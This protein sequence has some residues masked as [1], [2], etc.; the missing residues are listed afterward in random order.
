[1][2]ERSHHKPAPKMKVTDY[3]GIAALVTA[4][5]VAL[6]TLW[7]R[8]TKVDEYERM[9]KG[10]LAVGAEQVTILKFRVQRLE[11]D[12]RDLKHEMHDDHR[13]RSAMSSQ[14]SGRFTSGPGAGRI[15]GHGSRDIWTG[16]PLQ[17][18][19]SPPP[20]LSEPRPRS[21]SDIYQML[22]KGAKDGKDYQ[23]RGYSH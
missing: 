3:A 6:G 17:V 12:F 20:R 14:P 4:F 7:D 5:S 21:P 13:A 23:P 11:N 8:N 2:A 19:E 15:G 9:H 22:L 18:P 10:I 1:M 16:G